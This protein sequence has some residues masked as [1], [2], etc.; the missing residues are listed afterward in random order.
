[1]I[2]RTWTAGRGRSMNPT[3]IIW[4]PFAGAVIGPTILK[5][6]AAAY[7]VYVARRR[8][9]RIAAADAGRPI[10]AMLAASDPGATL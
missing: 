7:S 4:R 3:T 2:L 8:A 5:R 1:M 6:W 10:L 9:E